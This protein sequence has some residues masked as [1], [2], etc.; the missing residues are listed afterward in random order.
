MTAKLI[1]FY[2]FEEKEGQRKGETDNSSFAGKCNIILKYET[3]HDILPSVFVR[4]WFWFVLFNL[5]EHW[6]K[7]SPGLVQLVSGDLREI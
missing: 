4:D 1:L 6:S 5:M 7:D 3:R 2:F